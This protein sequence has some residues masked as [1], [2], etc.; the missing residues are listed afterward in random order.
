MV[1]ARIGGYKKAEYFELEPS[2]RDV[3]PDVHT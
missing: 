1:V 2:V 3:V